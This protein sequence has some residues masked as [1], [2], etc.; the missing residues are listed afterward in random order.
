MLPPRQWGRAR[1]AAL[2]CPVRRTRD[3]D[4]SGRRTLLWDLPARSIIH[5][6]VEIPHPDCDQRGRDEKILH[7]NRLWQHRPS[8]TKSACLRDFIVPPRQPALAAFIVRRD[9]AVDSSRS[10]SKTID[11]LLKQTPRNCRDENRSQSKYH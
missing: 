3:D 4:L 10:R 6:P 11:W 8:Q 1:P 7:P 5:H 2:Q 9:F